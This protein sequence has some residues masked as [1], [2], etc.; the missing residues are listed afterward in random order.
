MRKLYFYIFSCFLIVSINSYAQTD[1]VPL[2]NNYGV[3]DNVEDNY[4]FYTQESKS[5]CCGNQ[6]PGSYGSD[7]RAIC[8]YEAISRTLT[9]GDITSLQHS[10]SYYVSK[11]GDNNDNTGDPMN[12]Y[13]GGYAVGD[14]VNV[15]MVYL[16]DNQNLRG[17]KQ[18]TFTFKDPIVGV[19]EDWQ[20]SLYWDGT[21]FGNNNSNTFYPRYIDA[22]NTQKFRKRKLD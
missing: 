10:Y 22:T 8:T 15:Y 2:T 14:V 5:S 11:S 3:V 19:G 20:Q 17:S 13:S 7:K 1:Q 16:N 12:T 9:S 18:A 4:M 21:R 6:D